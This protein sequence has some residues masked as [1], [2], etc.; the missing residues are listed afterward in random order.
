MLFRSWQNEIMQNVII[1]AAKNAGVT[2]GDV[3]LLD[4]SQGVNI[5]PVL[6]NDPSFVNENGV[7]DRNRFVQFVQAIPQDDS[8]NLALYWDFLEDNIYN[9]QFFTKYISLLEKSNVMSPVELSKAIANNNTTYNVDFIMQPYGFALDTTINVSNQEIKAYYDTHKESFKQ[10]QSKDIEY[11]VFE[12][13]PSTEDIN[14]AEADINKVYP[15]FEQTTNMRAFLARNSDQPYNPYYFKT[16]ELKRVSP[17]LED[18]VSSA[19]VG[20]SL[21]PFKEDN[22]F[23]A[24]RVME[25]K[26]MPDSVFVK[27]VL[28]QGDDEAKADSLVNEAKRGADF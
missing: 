9:D 2:L 27:H 4:L 25:I 3:E 24:A 5:S 13:V 14:F 28:L 23:A 26:N 18:F 10:G 17:V 20:E 7:F 15:E 12:V 1:P 6:A 21:K 8:G 11:V 19:K 16:E 22:S